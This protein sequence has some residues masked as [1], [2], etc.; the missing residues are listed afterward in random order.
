MQVTK[1]LP[2]MSS[3]PDLGNL[4]PAVVALYQDFKWI[5]AYRI[6]VVEVM[7]SAEYWANSYS[8]RVE[9]VLIPFLN[10]VK[11]V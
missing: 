9:D 11:K 10:I 5:D 7:E 4:H 8:I 3:I 6:T 2:T 1:I